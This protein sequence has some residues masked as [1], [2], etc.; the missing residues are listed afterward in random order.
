MGPIIN[1]VVGM[2][3]EEGLNGFLYQVQVL[4]KHFSAAWLKCFVPE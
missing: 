1:E 2:F 3:L 4:A